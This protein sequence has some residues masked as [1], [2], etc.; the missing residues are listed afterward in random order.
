MTTMMYNCSGRR[1]HH[2]H[3]SF[4]RA[5]FILFGEIG[6]KF[7]HTQKVL[8]NTRKCLLLLHRPTMTKTTMKTSTRRKTASL[9]MQKKIMT[10]KN[11]NFRR[12]DSF[13]EEVKEVKE[14]KEQKIF[15]NNN[16]NNNNHPSRAFSAWRNQTGDGYCLASRRYSF[17]FRLASPCRIL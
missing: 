4:D 5:R 15:N 3:R 6:K 14:A 12:R 7:P 11:K 8:T 1:E 9:R 13:E 10:M 17:V 2:H 16:N